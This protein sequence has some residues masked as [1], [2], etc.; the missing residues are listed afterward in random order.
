[1]TAPATARARR[2][3]W[4]CH[5][6]LIVGLV[7]AATAS[8]A[9]AAPRLEV[10]DRGAA[11]EVIAHGVTA[12][13]ATITPRRQRLEVSLAEPAR[14][15]RLLAS[16]D[17]TLVA[18]EIVAGSPRRLS[19]KLHLDSARTRAHAARSRVA[20]LGDD[21]HLMI[22]R[23]TGADADADADA[24]ALPA[25]T[26]A[27]I[28]PD[29]EPAADA[30]PAVD[31]GADAPTPTAADVATP[32]LAAATVAGGTG[33]DAPDPVAAAAHADAPAP[34]PTPIGA[35][36][37][38]PGGLPIQAVAMIGL[39]GVAAIAWLIRRRRRHP[40]VGAAIEVIAQRVLG[41][42]Q[43]VWL[44]AGEREMVVG[45]AAQQVRILSQWRRPATGGATTTAPSPFAALL[46]AATA[47]PA[48]PPPP[49]PSPAVNGILRLR[50]RGSSAQVAPPSTDAIGPDDEG[51]ADDAIWARE[52]LAA[53]RP[54]RELPP[55]SR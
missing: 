32:E 53:T 8:V 25:W 51:E 44:A 41:K 50:A 13:D 24:S 7:V 10:I 39:V 1:M 29:A 15:T 5:R 6:G 49:A 14:K 9:A 35:L 21:L 3:S 33:A 11:V 20:Q 38:D 17:A 22:P 31:A 47:A 52:L 23:A 12:R 2:P 19:V 46:G 37:S 28:E 48:A 40:P 42:V 45:V 18:V 36:A 55:R 26:T 30:E 16:G 34:T 54:P 4:A 27:T 43:I